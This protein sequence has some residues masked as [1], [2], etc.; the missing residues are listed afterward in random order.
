[1]AKTRVISE[2][3]RRDSKDAV[4]SIIQVWFSSCWNVK[5]YE[6]FRECLPDAMAG[7]DD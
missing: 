7:V 2:M 3:L 4:E 1:M 5:T 6:M